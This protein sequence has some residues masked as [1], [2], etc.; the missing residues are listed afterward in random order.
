MMRVTMKDQVGSRVV[1]RFGQQ[2][3][4]EEGVN[5]QP[6]AFQCRLD[7]RVMEEGDAK[8]GVQAGEGP[9]QPVG[10]HLRVRDERLHLGLAEIAAM[11]TPKTTAEALGAGDDEQ[12]A[13]DI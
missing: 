11:G 13:V 2:I 4:A 6:L 3:A 1:Y 5:L 10:Q 7:G 12:N 8:V 9:L